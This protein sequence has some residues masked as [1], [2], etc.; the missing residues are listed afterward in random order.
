MIEPREE[1]LKLNNCFAERLIS[2]QNAK[3]EPSDEGSLAP[4]WFLTK[5]YNEDKVPYTKRQKTDYLSV[6]SYLKVYSYMA[7]ALIRHK[8]AFWQSE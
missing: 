7:I 2:V 1:I 4:N 3:H 5:T 8:V 6:Y